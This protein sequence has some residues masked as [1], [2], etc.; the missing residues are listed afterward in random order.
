MGVRLNEDEAW[1]M[2][3]NSHTG[4][5][6]TLRRDG[7]PVSLPMW[8]V[9]LDRKI[10]M[11]TLA[12]S[13]KALRIKRDQR[14]CFMVES[15]KAWKDLAAVV[16]PVRASLIEANAEEAQRALAALG[17]KYA[18]WGVPQKA[19]PEATRKHYGGG[20]VVIR[21]DPAGDMI[22]WNNAKIRLKSAV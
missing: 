22:T 1:E 6:T 11:R 21:L 14:A 5:I 17:T 7:W 8:F 2:L 13:K 4:T 16:V 18:G 12:A 10:Y 19:V 3:A 9:A 20:N 15:G